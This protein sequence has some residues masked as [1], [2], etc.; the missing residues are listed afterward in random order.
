VCLD[1]L[2]A[3]VA[4]HGDTEVFGFLHILTERL[5]RADAAALFHLPVAPEDHLAG[6]FGSLFD[7]TVPVRIHDGDTQVRWDGAWQALDPGN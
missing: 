1:S 7:H 3:V 4:S 2:A 6:M 5:R